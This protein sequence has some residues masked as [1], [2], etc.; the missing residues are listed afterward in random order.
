MF[1]VLVLGVRVTRGGL[2]NLQNAKRKDE[3]WRNIH[4]CTAAHTVGWQHL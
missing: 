3:I 4:H 1:K 2:L